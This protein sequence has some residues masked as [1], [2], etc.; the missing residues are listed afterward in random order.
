MRVAGPAPSWSRSSSFMVAASGSRGA[1]VRARREMSVEIRRVRGRAVPR[2]TSRS[3]SSAGFICRPAELR[4]RRPDLRDP[5]HAEHRLDSPAREAVRR[6][7]PRRSRSSDVALR[8]RSRSG[9][10]ATSTLACRPANGSPSSAAPGAGKTT[11]VNLLPRFYDVTGGAIRST[12]P[13]SAT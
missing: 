10:P 7:G 1:H 11:L 2:C 8:L 3:R 5:G 6:G 4:R 13:T 9:D 12:A